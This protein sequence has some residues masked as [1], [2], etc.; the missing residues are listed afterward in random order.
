MLRPQ[1]L[2]SGFEKRF[3]PP[4]GAGVLTGSAA[5]V[6]HIEGPLSTAQHGRATMGDHGENLHAIDQVTVGDVLGPNHYPYSGK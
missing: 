3:L 1:H 6:A 5:Q 2:R 4:A